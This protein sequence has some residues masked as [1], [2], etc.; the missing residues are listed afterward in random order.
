MNSWLSVLMQFVMKRNRRK[1]DDNK[2]D[3]DDYNKWN[4]LYGP[5]WKE[6]CILWNLMPRKHRKYNMNKRISAQNVKESAQI[7]KVFPLNGC[8]II[9]PLELKPKKE[10]PS[11]DKRTEYFYFEFILHITFFQIGKI[12]HLTYNEGNRNTQNIYTS[13]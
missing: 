2:D 9:T 3:D 10:K 11:M 6:E 7:W 1:N 5:K 13:V 8:L 12:S 4:F